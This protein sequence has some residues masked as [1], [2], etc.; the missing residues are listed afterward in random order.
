VFFERINI[1]LNDSKIKENMMQLERN[2]RY[3]G[4]IELVYYNNKPCF[5]IYIS[6]TK[7]I[8]E[9]TAHKLQK[10]QNSKYIYVDCI[11]NELAEKIFKLYNNKE[12]TKYYL[13]I[14]NNG[15]DVECIIAFH[16]DNTKGKDETPIKYYNKWWII[17]GISIGIIILASIV[18][19]TRS[20]LANNSNVISVKNEQKENTYEITNDY[21]GTYKFI[22]NE[23]S[24]TT[25]GAININ[26]GNVRV[27]FNSIDSDYASKTY[28]G[29]CGL[30]KDDNSTFYITIMN[31]AHERIREFK[32]EKS[33]KN[34]ICNSMTGTSYRKMELIYVND[35]KNIENIYN[36]TLNQE[37]EK[38]EKEEKIRKEKEEQ[39]FKASCKMFTFEQIARNPDKFK[40][41]NV[42]IIGEVV[43]VLYGSNSV[44][45]RVNITKKG[46]YSTYYT[47]TVYVTYYTKPNE[48]KILDN[49]IITI[50]GTAQGDCSYTSIMGA[51]VTLPKIDANFIEINK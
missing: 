42:K 31:S 6:K 9:K 22:I 11:K 16:K 3:G 13:T 1:K 33:D 32:C 21:N 19:Y 37:K 26:G 35:D 10:E 46:S 44:D 36:E 38:K 5:N 34:L 2:I 8:N 29:F 14:N 27:K 17:I 43:Q 4:K 12:I 7:K 23:G 40:G 20:L 39:E 18:N 47:D 41:T 50:Y 45:L 51:K 15:N 25:V 28:N 48:D 24:K 49:D 30:N